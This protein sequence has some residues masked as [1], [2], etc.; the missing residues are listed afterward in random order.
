MQAHHFT[1]VLLAAALLIAS[2]TSQ[3]ES[4][5]AKRQLVACKSEALWSEMHG[6]QEAKDQ[7][8]VTKLMSAKQ[9]VLIAAGEPINIVRPGILT[10]TIEYNGMT[11]YTR[12][13]TLR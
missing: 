9:C 5:P 1:G 12:A 13:D 7:K 10:A 4:T 6:Y 3:A 8:G 11:L 2:P